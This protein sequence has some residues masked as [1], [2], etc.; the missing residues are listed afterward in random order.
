MPAGENG[1][2]DLTQRSRFV[3]GRAVD[4]PDGACR[5]ALDGGTGEF[6]ART[7]AR[8]SVFDNR[9]TAK[10]AGKRTPRQAAASPT[11]RGR[12][13][14]A[15]RIRPGCTPAAGA[16][17]PT[18]GAG[19]PPPETLARAVREAPSAG[20]R[21][22]GTAAVSGRRPAGRR[23]DCRA[24]AMRARGCT[25]RRRAEPAGSPQ[26]A[27]AR[28]ALRWGARNVGGT[29]RRNGAPGQA[30]R[31]SPAQRWRFPGRGRRAPDVRRT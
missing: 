9:L 19:L 6:M 24:R 8:R 22:T 3:A 25:A 26:R 1:A 21:Y 16:P 15:A 18:P 29:P 4:A 7:T 12:C 20:D 30:A 10:G 17:H 31:V 13:S 27:S 5:I 2:G 11:P 14:P 23:S 28:P